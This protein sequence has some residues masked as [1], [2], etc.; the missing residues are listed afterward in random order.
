MVELAPEAPDHIAVGLSVG[1]SGPVVDVIGEGSRQRR[2]RL[3]PGAGEVEVLEA[4]R[5]G[6][7]EVVAGEAGAEAVGHRFRLALVGAGALIAPAPP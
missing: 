4:G 5:P 7:L 3:H 1:M 2:R 6:Y